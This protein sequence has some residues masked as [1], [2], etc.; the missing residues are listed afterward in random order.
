MLEGMVSHN[1]VKNILGK[2]ENS[3]YQHFLLFPTMFY[4]LSRKNFASA[5]ILN[6]L[7]SKYFQLD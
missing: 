3:G 6:L 4:I 2:G 5:A 7:S 1:R